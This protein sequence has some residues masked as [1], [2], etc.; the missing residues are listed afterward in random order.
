MFGRFSYGS[1]L[2]DDGHHLSKILVQEQDLTCE[3]PIEKGYY[4]NKEKIETERHLSPLWRDW[5]KGVPFV[6][7]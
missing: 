5:I 1:L 2:L 4:S 7:T 3:S 6:F